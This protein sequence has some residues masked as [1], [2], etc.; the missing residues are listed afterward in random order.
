MNLAVITG[1]SVGI[2]L[3]TAR[4]FHDHGYEIVNISRRLCP[5]ANATSLSIDLSDS[6]SIEQHAEGIASRCR[7]ATS[8]VLI[9]NAAHYVNDHAIEGSSSGLQH[10][11]AINVLAPD[12]LNRHLV[13]HFA[14]GSSVIYVGSTLSEKAVAG[15]FSY[16]T[17]KHAQVGMVRAMCQDLAGTGVHTAMICPGFTDTEMLRSHVPEDAMDSVASMS[18]FSRLIQPEEIA[19]TIFWASQN[20]VINGAV[21]HAN[22]GQIES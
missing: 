3:A 12:L 19:A 10:S 9:H 22:L 8:T 1:A 6:Q 18:A 5:L 14:A 7:E 11:V 20:A 15:T 17:T 4:L 21:I 2:G 13:P 16:V